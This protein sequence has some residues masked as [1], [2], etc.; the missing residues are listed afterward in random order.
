MSLYEYAAITGAIVWVALG[1][2]FA[3][4]LLTGASWIAGLFGARLFKDLRRVYHL[5]VIG[6][7]LDRLEKE[8]S[9]CFE[10]S[11]SANGEGAG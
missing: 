7:W 8:G 1:F 4:V 2:L 3:I 10:K 6:Y 11:D 9:H 5:R